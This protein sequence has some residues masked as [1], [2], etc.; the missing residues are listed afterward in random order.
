V[1][2]VDPAAGEVVW[3]RRMDAHLLPVYS[4]LADV[5]GDGWREIVLGSSAVD[6]LHGEQLHGASDD[7]ARVFVLR[8]DG[9]TL[10]SRSLSGPGSYAWATVADL[11]GSGGQEIVTTSFD[12]RAAAGRIAVWSCDGDLLAERTQTRGRP[13]RLHVLDKGPGFAPSVVVEISGEDL[14]VLAWVDGRLATVARRPIPTGGMLGLVADLI[15]EAPGDEIAVTDRASVE[16]YDRELR[17]LAALDFRSVTEH[18]MLLFWQPDAETR[19]LGI[20]EPRSLWYEFQPAPRNPQV[21]RYAGGAAVLLAAGGA[22]WRRRRRRRRTSETETDPAVLRELRL[23]L[24]ARLAKGSHEKIGALQGLRRLVWRLN[25][26]AA[27]ESAGGRDDGPATGT[28]DPAASTGTAA[29]SGRTTGAGPAAGA[30]AAM[31]RVHQSVTEFVEQAL[32]RLAEILALARRTGVP[33][34]LLSTAA[35]VLGDLRTLL[36]E[37]PASRE[38]AAP[39]QARA[40]NLAVEVEAALQRIRQ[41]VEDGFRCDLADAVDAVLRAQ[42]DAIAGAGVTVH[43]PPS[44][45]QG[46]GGPVVAVDPQDLQ[47]VLDNLVGNALRSMAD[48]SL[49]RLEIAWAVSGGRVVCTVTDTG[50]GIA[51]DDWE[52]VFEE[53]WSDHPG[54]GYGLARSRRDLALYGG[55]LRVRESRPGRGTTFELVLPAAR[56]RA[57]RD[58]EPRSERAGAPKAGRRTA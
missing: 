4:Q 25:A 6:N 23:Q 31:A 32:P 57:G 14:E 33:A 28:N 8:H 17:P 49:R 22:V 16:I 29:G 50:W 58:R 26:A 56:R 12:P 27:L 1:L 3:R 47:F 39:L 42:A 10:W 52:A 24:L 53:G 9:S 34:H 55:T 35:D 18:P 13:T 43:R 48:A 21:L 7:S 51:T 45:G 44:P 15:P 2:A 36:Q 11:D 46:S 20:S 37:V 54:G 30:G 5:D 40:T 19:L 41:S 38:I